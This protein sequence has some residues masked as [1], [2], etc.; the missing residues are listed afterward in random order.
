MF[1]NSRDASDIANGIHVSTQGTLWAGIRLLPY[2]LLAL[3]LVDKG[4]TCFDYK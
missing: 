2:Q 4:G 3:Q 1:A